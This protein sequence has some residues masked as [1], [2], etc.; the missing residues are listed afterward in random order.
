[1]DVGVEFEVGEGWGWEGRKLGEGGGEGE[2]D[3]MVFCEEGRSGAKVLS[4][5]GV[6]SLRLRLGERRED[7]A[8]ARGTERAMW[9]VYI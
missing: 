2:D 4:E 5:A 6:A 9:C 7:C 3:G 1:V 8:V